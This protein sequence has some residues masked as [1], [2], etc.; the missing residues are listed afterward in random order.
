MLRSRDTG[1]IHIASAASIEIIGLY[2]AEYH[3]VQW[4][5]ESEKCVQILNDQA[6]D[7]NN[8]DIDE[9]ILAFTLYY[10]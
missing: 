2:P 5:P 9:I 4:R 7:V 10:N 6:N 3:L 8:I 1:V